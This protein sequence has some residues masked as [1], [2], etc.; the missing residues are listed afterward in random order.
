[1]PE[2]GRALEPSITCIRSAAGE[3]VIAASSSLRTLFI[4]KPPGAVER[5]YDPLVATPSSATETRN[6]QPL[7]GWRFSILIAVLGILE[8]YGS[9]RH[10]RDLVYFTKPG[11]MLAIIA[12]AATRLDRARPR[13]GSL[14]LIGLG[15]SLVGDV[16]LMLPGD[17]FVVGLVSFLVAHI[18]YIAAFRTDVKRLG[19]LVF[20]G[21]LF[22]VGAVIYSILLPNLGSMKLPV[23]IYL[24]VILTMAWQAL[25]RWSYMRDKQA[26]LAAIGA[27]LFVI[28]DSFIAFN[29]FLGSF[30]LAE[31]LIMTTYFGAQWMIALS[32]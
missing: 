25:S 20:A 15:C 13:Y 3:G 31:G 9:Y 14:I 32:V 7:L 28:S 29:R 24:A 16:M 27:L 6:R 30:L 21:L 23:S 17:L 19:S 22:G 11:A 1:M 26:L 12:L 18:F 8:I 2:P 10:Q 4:G 5:S